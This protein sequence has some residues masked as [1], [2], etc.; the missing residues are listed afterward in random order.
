M[1]KRLSHRVIRN[2]IF[3]FIGRSWTI[4]V[5]LALT[6][7]ILSRLG[8]E[9]YGV[10]SLVFVVTNYFGLLD[11]GAGTSYVVYIS[12]YYTRQ[13]IHSLNRLVNTGLFFYLLLAMLVIPIVWLFN[14]QFVQ[15]FPVPASLAG[16]A[17]FVLVGVVMIYALNNAFGVFQALLQGMQ[18]MDVSNSLAIGLSLFEAVSTV[19]FL[20]Q[21]Y[22]LRGLLITEALVGAA[23]TLGTIIMAYRLL[24]AMRIS[25]S[26]FRKDMLQRILR[27]GLKV[28]V[29]RLAELGSTQADKLIIG[30]FLGLSMVT[31][32]DVSSKIVLTA[33]R[34]A[35][36]LVSATLPAAAEVAARGDSALLKSLY[37]RSAKY[38]TLVAAPL[39]LFLIPVAGPLLRAWLG[40]GFEQSV[41]LLQVLAIGHFTHQLTG[42]G[43]SIVKGMG[44][45]EVEMRYT[46]IL[47]V[48][49]VVL[50][51]GLISR[52]GFTGAL[53]ATPVSLVVSSLYFLWIFHRLIGLPGTGVFWEVYGKPVAACLLAGILIYGLQSQWP[54]GAWPFAQLS[55]SRLGT[56][57]FIGAEGMAFMV[58]YLLAM[59]KMQYLDAYDLGL[60]RTTR[61]ALLQP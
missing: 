12:E 39:L 31:F 48:L 19:F 23:G 34:I 4:L 50:A 20:Q 15:L 38:L 56:L 28:Q 57:L 14:A 24:P 17:R 61:E 11:L 13:D 9:A 45:P 55:G 60:W 59:W 29:S 44:Y 51:I 1:E 30:A 25:V 2:T 52:L 32:Y 6:P 3:N 5:A 35:R 37:L 10:W 47:L 42:A 43:S 26:Y 53:I 7:Y 41:P 18:R 27:Y 33:K 8:L 58:I 40:P 22:G 54:A 36:V 49:D 46:L 21:G 16:D